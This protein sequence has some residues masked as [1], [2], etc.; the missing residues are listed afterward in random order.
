[1]YSPS[2]KMRCWVRIP[3]EAV[4][5]EYVCISS[6]LLMFSFVSSSFVTGSSL[7]KETYQ[8]SVRFMAAD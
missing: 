4:M 6:M 8:Q 1:M 5:Y 7:F 2:K 3:F